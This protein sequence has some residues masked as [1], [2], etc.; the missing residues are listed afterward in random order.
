MLPRH[1]HDDGAA[2]VGSSAY[3]VTSEY[4][5]A[6]STKSVT[7]RHVTSGPHAPFT[8]DEGINIF[9]SEGAHAFEVSEHFSSLSGAVVEAQLSRRTR[10]D[11]EYADFVGISVSER[12]KRKGHLIGGCLPCILKPENDMWNLPGQHIDDAQVS[13]VQIR[14]ELPFGGRPRYVHNIFGAFRGLSGLEESQEYQA[15]PYRAQDCLNDCRPEHVSG[16]LGHAFLGIQIALFVDGVSIGV[17]GF[18]CASYAVQVRRDLRHILSGTGLPAE[19]EI[20]SWSA[21]W[22][23]SGP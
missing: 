2:I 12:N 7:I 16:P 19:A 3:R 21:S 6:H 17:L 5:A 10:R 4:G 1:F 11:S 20:A 22:A 15:N 13:G 9:R 14:T 23:L 8:T 18:K